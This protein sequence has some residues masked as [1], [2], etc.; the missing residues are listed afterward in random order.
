M[1]VANDGAKHPSFQHIK[2][3]STDT[4][5]EASSAATLRNTWTRRRPL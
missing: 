2:L 4:L 5:N 1:S 3:L